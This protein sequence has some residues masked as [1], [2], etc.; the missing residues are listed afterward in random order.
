MNSFKTIINTFSFAFIMLFFAS[1][2]K[3]TGEGPTR[4]EMRDRRGFSEV[5]MRVGGTIYIK[6]DSEYKLEVTAQQNILENLETNIVGNK[7]VLKFKD[8]VR[9]KSHEDIV[10]RISSPEVDGVRLSGSGNVYVT[11]ALD[12]TNFW[13]EV[14]GSGNLNI[15]SLAV[16][17]L[18]ARI[19]GSGNIKVE[20]GSVLEETLKI[21]GSGSMELTNVKGKSA[22]TTT[23]GSGSIRLQVSDRLNVS[24]A[25]SGSVY[26]LGNPIITT[27]ISGSGSVVH[28]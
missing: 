22:F 8:G 26:Y 10:I 14:S 6:K 11:G 25:G 12:Q 24:I 20:S 1:C 15:E 19:S 21:A 5:D 7:L 16:T 17:N 13:T 18:D 27:K 3:I 23:T 4:T 2:E 9:V 28:L